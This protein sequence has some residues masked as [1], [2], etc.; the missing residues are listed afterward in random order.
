VFLPSS[1][2]YMS[3]S[4]IGLES[5]CVLL[6]SPS[7]QPLPMMPISACRFWTQANMPNDGMGRWTTAKEKAVDPSLFRNGGLTYWEV[8]EEPF[9]PKTSVCHLHPSPSYPRGEQIADRPRLSLRQPTRALLRLLP[10]A[11][12]EASPLPLLPLSPR[13]L[14]VS[15]LPRTLSTRLLPEPTSPSCPLLLP[16]T[17][18]RPMFHPQTP[19]SSNR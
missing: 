16:P 18:T 13:P 17:S 2:G 3:F 15:R 9:K 6:K 1:C 8:E 5:D 11:K 10:M 7:F 19:R 12:T 4:G 14:S